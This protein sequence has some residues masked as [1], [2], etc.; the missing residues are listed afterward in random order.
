[1]CGWSALAN[2]ETLKMARAI[3]RSVHR[4]A[5]RLRAERSTHDLSMSKRSVL[6]RLFRD[7]SLTATDLAAQ[8][9]IQPQSLTRLIADL[10]KRRLITRHQDESD[11][12]H[13]HIEITSVGRDLL[14]RDAQEQDKWLAAAMTSSMTSV[15]RELLT[16]GARL[17]ESLADVNPFANPEGK[18]EKI[19]ET[20]T[21]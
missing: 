8:E 7:G 13:L 17:L 12:R 6:G 15:E 10:E 3:R 14:I 2:D 19:E 21:D 20:E 9:R 4:I 11:R 1:M 5:R 16:L 18:I